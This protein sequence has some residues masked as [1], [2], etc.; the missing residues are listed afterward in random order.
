MTPK[1]P[2]PDH[3]VPV[4]E[5]GP[6][7]TVSLEELSSDP[8][9]RAV[10]TPAS[11]DLVGWRCAACAYPVTQVALRCPVCRGEVGEA[12]FAGHGEV[13]AST[14][15]RVRVPGHEPP[16]AVAYVRLDDGP[17]VLAHTPG[18]DPIAPG[19]RV[20]IAAVTPEGDLVAEERSG[21]AA[22]G[23]ENPA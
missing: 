15:L 23:Q 22:L 1:Q 10:E 21:S 18:D 6:M 2:A 13:W 5:E 14:C 7:A 11:I 8:R 17:R 12:R 4:S 9:P 3:P 19:T 20:R 16:F